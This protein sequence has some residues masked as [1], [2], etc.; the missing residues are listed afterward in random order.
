MGI[1]QFVFHLIISL[2]NYRL[3]PII[4][5]KGL[6]TFAYFIPYAAC[7]VVWPLKNNVLKCFKNIRPARKIF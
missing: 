5:K 2:R 6:L 7:S 1:T 4:Y 3:L